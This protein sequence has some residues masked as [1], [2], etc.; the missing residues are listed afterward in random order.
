[1]PRARFAMG[2]DTVRQAVVHTVARCVRL[3]HERTIIMLMLMFGLGV[4]GMLWDVSRLQSNL[5]ASIALQD[6][7][8]YAQALTEFRT[9]YTSEVVETVRPRGIAVTHD[10]ETHA[11]AIPLPVTLT[12]LL[13]KRISA[14]EAGAQVRL[15]SP[16]PF[17]TRR[18]EG[19]LHDAFGQAAWDYLQHNPNA[20]FHR[21]ED[22]QG[23]LSLR[24]ATADLMRPSCVNCHNTHPASPKTGWKTGDVRGV[25]EVSFPLDTA[26]AQTRMSL[27]GTFALMAVMSV[28]GLSGLTMVISRLRR[29]ST[30]LDQRARHLESEI[31]ERQRV[32]EALRESE[33]KYRHIINAAADAIISLD[34]QGLVREFND[35][36]E[37]MF[38]FTKAEIL[39]KPLTPLM[40]PHLR[41][42]HTAGLQRYLTT[43]QRHLPRWSNV[44]LP[45]MTKDGR[46]FPLEVSFS[47]LEAGDKKFLTGVL[48]DITERKLAEGELR[49]ARETAEAATQA[50]SAFLANMSHEL[51]TPMNA[52]MGFT[53][54]VMRR[55][56]DLL[57]QRQYENLEK[58]LISAEHL[59]T[60]I[61][62]ILDLSKI[63]AGHMEIHPVSFQLETLVDVCLRTLEPMLQSERIRLIKEIEPALALLSTDQDKVQQ[64]LM[65]L[66]SNAVKFTPAGTI[67]ITAQQHNGEITVA[68]ADTGIGI[69]AEALKHV[70]E[71][72][73]Q[74]DNST[75]RQ[76]GGTGLGLSISRRLAQLLGGD[77]TVQSV[78]G[79]GS[80]FTV[81][82]PLHYAAPPPVT[83][84]TTLPSHA[85]L[86]KQREPERVILVI[87]DDPDV[88]YLVQ[89]N[90]TEAGYQVIGATSGEDG[91][92]Q[93]R[94][95][96]PFAITLD[97]LMPH[98]D[99]WQLLHDLKSD[100]AT[101]DIP[102]IVLSIVDNKPLGY[103]LGAFD[104]L[105]K[106]FDR[107]TILAALARIPP[108]RGRLLVV[109]DDPQVV[110][111]VRQLLEGEPYEVLAAADGQEA[112]EVIPRQRPDIVLLDLLMPRLDGF[113]VI[114]SLRQDP[115]HQQ[116]PV[117]VLTAK[118]LTAAEYALLDQSVRAVLQKQGLDRSTL[119]EELQ[120]LLRVYRT[121]HGPRGQ[122]TATP[123]G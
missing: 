115:Q 46:E 91:L 27:R 34:E 20:S 60:L 119:I 108:Q 102:I 120:G 31:A 103:R 58:I 95:L 78:L 69:P 112:L 42:A 50:K 110:D 12:M 100:A 2:V 99:G 53:R 38:G 81:T 118:T 87:D 13:G 45:G 54:L 121:R 36:A 56:Q 30:D 24:Y 15:Y 117:I 17:P 114:E 104:Y 40:P 19:G 37:Q 55:S 6:A 10:Y 79:V 59:L 35:A 26:V 44:E 11:G 33:E 43:G 21:I 8:L 22:V 85:E 61:N 23:R 68:V 116:L 28:V 29:N 80:T 82:L 94:T 89:E 5:I 70:F 32:E 97:I 93:A 75:T 39:G 48:R 105:L 123:E 62:D 122:H 96:H 101:Q 1:M 49:Q 71:E 83:H 86:L 4:G 74:V 16:Y 90:L 88:I 57:P 98:K 64:I 52:I 63:E 14:H 107:E 73:R 84:A 18:Q 111:L 7:S 51:R 72:F 67:T 113:A 77:I 76:Y 25:L 66:L 109:D 106:P 47:L 41:D 3:L 9:L 65:N 92:Q